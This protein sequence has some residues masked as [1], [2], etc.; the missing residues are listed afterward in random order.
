MPR[1]RVARQRCPA[2]GSG[3]GRARCRWPASAATA[4]CAHSPTSGVTVPWVPPGV[5][6]NSRAIRASSEGTWCILVHGDWLASLQVKRH[7][8]RSRPVT[9]V[10]TDTGS[11]PV[12]GAQENR[13]SGPLSRGPS[14][15]PCELGLPTDQTTGSPAADRHALVRSDRHR[16]WAWP[17]AS[18]SHSL[19]AIPG[20]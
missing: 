12:E 3:Q 1:R 6:C 20:G 17:S 5:S 2:L 11:S 10:V 13:R 4:A 16:Q 18:R 7:F 14:L 15:Y 19:V 9:G 8:C